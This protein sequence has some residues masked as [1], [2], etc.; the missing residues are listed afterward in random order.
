MSASVASTFDNNIETE[1]TA[2]FSVITAV[3]SVSG[4][5][6]VALV[7]VIV[8]MLS[9]K[10]IYIEIKLKFA[11]FQHASKQMSKQTTFLSTN[12]TRRFFKIGMAVTEKK[13]RV[14]SMTFGMYTLI[15]VMSCSM[16][17]I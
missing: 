13:S 12:I 17:Y 5:V 8:V 6:A 14:V 7:A 3:G 11:F 10:M 4:A 2:S 15:V 9:T 16:A 1:G